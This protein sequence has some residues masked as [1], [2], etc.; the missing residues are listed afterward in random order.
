MTQEP[1]VTDDFTTDDVRYRVRE[2]VHP[3]YF[4]DVGTFGLA[5]IK[6][7][8]GAIDYGGPYREPPQ[9][10]WLSKATAWPRRKVARGLE[11]LADWIC[12]DRDE[13]W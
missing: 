10:S 11:R 9:P 6:T 2:V 8:G 1:D 5:P 13:G 4:G 7:E 12:R 3:P